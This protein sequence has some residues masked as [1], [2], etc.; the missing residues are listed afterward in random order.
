[1]KANQ[2][3]DMWKTALKIAYRLSVLL[4]VSWLAWHGDAAAA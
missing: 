1:M 2:P 3:S 4:P